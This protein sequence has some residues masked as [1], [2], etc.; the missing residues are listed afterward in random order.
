MFPCFFVLVGL[1]FFSKE[2]VQ[3]YPAYKEYKEYSAY[4]SDI[5]DYSYYSYEENR[6]EFEKMEL[7]KMIFIH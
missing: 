2:F 4:R 6:T 3:R 7:V 5:V 1:S